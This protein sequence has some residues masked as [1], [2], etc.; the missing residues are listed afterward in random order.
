MSSVREAAATTKAS[1]S[2]QAAADAGT[3]AMTSGC[4][5]HKLTR[6]KAGGEVWGVGGGGFSG[7]VRRSFSDDA[8]HSCRKLVSLGWD[9]T[10]SK[11]PGLSTLT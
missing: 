1:S 8:T 5:Y 9:F 6:D 7:A 11:F 4:V 2:A 3:R 10:R